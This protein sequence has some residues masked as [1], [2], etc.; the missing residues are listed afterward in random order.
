MDI[1][2][3]ETNRIK[4]RDKKRDPHKMKVDGAGIKKVILSLHNKYLLDKT[5][6]KD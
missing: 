3:R 1:D 6:R 4:R 2:D 5:K